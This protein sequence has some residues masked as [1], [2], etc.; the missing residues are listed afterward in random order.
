MYALH[1]WTQYI[2]LSIYKLRTILL[3]VVII[4]TR[5]LW[6]FFNSMFEPVW[7]DVSFIE[8]VTTSMICNVRSHNKT[9]LAGVKCRFNQKHYKIKFVVSTV[10]I[11]HYSWIASLF[12]AK[13]PLNTDNLDID[14]KIAA[15]GERVRITSWSKNVHLLAQQ[16]FKTIVCPRVSI[17]I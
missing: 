14:L 3:Q 8:Y 17:L 15:K 7:L 16:T 12:E 6:I 13:V 5:L 9:S 1:E 11:F 2:F 4:I 10:P